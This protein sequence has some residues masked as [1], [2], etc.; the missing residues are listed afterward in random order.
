MSNKMKLDLNGKVG[1]VTGSASGIGREIALR[2]SLDGARVVLAD[3]NT[4]GI[5]EVSDLINEYGESVAVKT[6]VTSEKDVKNM[7]DICI[8]KYYKI[9]FI[10]SNAG[11]VGPYSFDDTTVEDWDSVFAVNVRGMFLCAKYVLPYMKERKQGRVVFTA[12]TN[13]EKPGGY[14]IAYR[15]S[16]A[17]VAMMAKSLAL[18]A[19]PYNIT[20]NSISPGVVLTPIEKKIIKEVIDK[21]GISFDE[22]VESRAK[23]IPMGRFTDVKDIADVAEFLLSDNASF[24]TGQ[25]IFVNGGEW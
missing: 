2:L 23:R 9:D 18:Y 1:I 14:V 16:K 25:Q 4:E 12:S 8:E 10:F 22:Y 15:A 5:N 21:K 7:L 6:D 20:V 13:A 11:I 24:I 17:A 3:V 19:A